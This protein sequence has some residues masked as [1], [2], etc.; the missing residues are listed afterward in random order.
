MEAWNQR[1]DLWSNGVFN[2]TSPTTQAYLAPPSRWGHFYMNNRVVAPIF[3]SQLGVSSLH[4][5]YPT[6][7]PRPPQSILPPDLFERYANMAFWRD[8]KNCKAYRIANQ[9]T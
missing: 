1:L 5:V 7:G 2:I 9:P 4:K 6:V 8:L 3:G